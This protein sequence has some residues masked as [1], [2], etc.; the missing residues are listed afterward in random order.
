MSRL[1]AASLKIQDK[2]LKGVTINQSLAVVGVGVGVFKNLKKN[3]PLYK[4]QGKLVRELKSPAA[5]L[6]L[7]G[8]VGHACST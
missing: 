8:T 1:P 3:Q 7:L 5:S 6:C 4:S 2:I